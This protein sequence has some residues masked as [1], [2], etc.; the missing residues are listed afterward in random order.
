MS[1][2][3]KY[4]AVSQPEGQ[5]IV[6]GSD[7]DMGI[8]SLQNVGTTQKIIAAKRR[9]FIN[10]RQSEL[11]EDKRNVILKQDEN[12]EAEEHED[13]DQA[14]QLQSR[15]LAEKDPTSPVSEA[16]KVSKTLSPS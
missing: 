10:M 2:D 15:Q 13:L 4:G 8:A 7:R 5:Y 9:S 1:D 6:D 12:E 16:L 3:E 11:S 14:P